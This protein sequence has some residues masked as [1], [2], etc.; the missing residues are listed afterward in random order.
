MYTSYV[1]NFVAS[2]CLFPAKR[3]CRGEVCGYCAAGNLLFR[4]DFLHDSSRR[5]IPFLF[6][7][8]VDPVWTSQVSIYQ[9]D[10]WPCERTPME[11]RQQYCRVA[12]KASR[13][14]EH[15][16]SQQ[17]LVTQ[18]FLGTFSS[19]IT[20]ARSVDLIIIV[21]SWPDKG[22]RLEIWIIR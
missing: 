12:N 14:T 16:T 10:R 11:R 4:S 18:C 6:P 20:V 15:R 1:Q 3:E 17:Y 22:T 8:R 9:F 13:M 19:V 21:I 5:R 2:S 7:E